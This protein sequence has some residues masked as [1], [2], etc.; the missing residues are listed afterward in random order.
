MVQ[1][2][3][4]LHFRKR[5]LVAVTIF[6]GASLTTSMLAV[7]FDVGDKIKAELGSFGANL[8][9]LSLIHI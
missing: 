5:L 9:V 8:Q 7:M 2:A 4:R 1:Q 3:L 6:L